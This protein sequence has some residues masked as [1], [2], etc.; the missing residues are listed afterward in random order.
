MEKGPRFKIWLMSMRPKT[1]PAACAPVFI[2]LAIA[3]DKVSIN[4]W[5]A[6][7]T[8]IAALLIQIGTNLANDYYDYVKG[9]DT[10]LR[11][12]PLR[13]TQA[14]LISKKHMKVAFITA[15]S[16]AGLCGIYLV[17]K[18]GL[19]ILIIGL[20]SIAFGI[21]YTAGPFPLGYNGL[22][23]LF[24]FIFFGPVAVMGTYYLQTSDLNNIVFLASIPA[25]FLSV[26]ILVANNLRDYK[27]D[28]ESGKKTLIVIIGYR[29]GLFQYF[30]SI[31][32]SFTIPI[33][34]VIITKNHYF[35]LLSVLVI[36]AAIRPFRKILSTREPEKIISVLAQ[37]SLILFVYSIIFSL[38]W[39]I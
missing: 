35:S 9:K 15:F 20:L 22:G 33:I 2:G 28:K 19:P 18:G 7:V 39:I 10:H 23:D 5:T 27:S 26:A 38:G 12:G 16:L 36:F 37:T 1:L 6:F 32:I 11:I 4:I 13:A 25:G 29:F 17:F 8:I 21:L 31:L 3:Y 30:F 24:V 34:L 14:G